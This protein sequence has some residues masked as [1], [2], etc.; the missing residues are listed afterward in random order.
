MMRWEHKL[1]DVIG[2]DL[3]DADAD[4]LASYYASLSD[5]VAAFATEE[6]RNVE[7]ALRAVPGPIRR[8]QPR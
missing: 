6:L 5:A 2:V 3:S 7:P 4:A 1:R 8:E